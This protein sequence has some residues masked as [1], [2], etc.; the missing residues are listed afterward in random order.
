VINE[1]TDEPQLG[2]CSKCGEQLYQGAMAER[3]KEY[4]N[5][6]SS[7]SN[8]MPVIP[9]VTLQNPMGWEYTVIKMIT[10]QITMGTGVFSEIASSFSDMV[11]NPS[12]SYGEKI[13]AGEND[14]FMQLRVQALNVGANAVIGT[15]I[16]YSEMGGGKNLIMVCMAGTAIRLKNMEMVSQT[17]EKEMNLLFEQ[18]KRIGYLKSLAE[19]NS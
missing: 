1:Y 2:Y 3:K 13:K 5:L 8:L 14:C 11:G 16:D 17:F 9:V 10:A 19:T 7:I 18:N 15:D 12:K 4:Y 6:Y